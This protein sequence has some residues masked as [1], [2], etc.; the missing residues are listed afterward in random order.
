MSLNAIPPSINTSDASASNELDTTRRQKLVTKSS[1]LTALQHRHFIIF[2][3]VPNVVALAAIPYHLFVAPIR[4][5]DIVAFLLLW[6][7]TG[8][9]VTVGYHRLFTHRAFA[10]PPSV[11]MTLAFCGA[12]AGQGPA[13]SWAAIHRRHHEMSDKPGD[14]HSPN[15]H[16]DTF[17]GAFRGLLHSHYTW[18]IEHEYPNVAHYAP[19]LLKDRAIAVINRNY[20]AIALSGLILPGVVAGLLT[21][22][23]QAAVSG[24]LWGGFIRM[25]VLGH[26]IWAI[27]SILHRFG[28]QPFATGDH[29]HN[30][31]IVSLLTFGES[32]H[33]N[34]HAFQTSAKFGLRYGWSDPGW[35]LVCLLVRIGLA[36]DVRQPA[37]DLINQRLQ[38]GR[39]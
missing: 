4:T 3:V 13:I 38:E 11:R 23:W 20:Y 27:N 1:Y 16:G 37:E 33:N 28:W 31:G 8:L 25:A 24:A 35:W 19:D 6:A 2:D 5:S 12:L 29:S 14:P 30:A 34:H 17:V 18:M 9:G 22:Q 7:A 36:H 10:A 39:V 21:W 32:W 15:L 26:T